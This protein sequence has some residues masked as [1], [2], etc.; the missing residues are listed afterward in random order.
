MYVKRD[1][2]YLIKDEIVNYWN[3]FLNLKFGYIDY[4]Y[5]AYG[6]RHKLKLI[7]LKLRFP[8][9]LVHLISFLLG[10]KSSRKYLREIK[11]KG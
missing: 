2:I 9:V 7:I 3:D 10:S 5:L 1:Y 8:R 11:L 4:M 6:A